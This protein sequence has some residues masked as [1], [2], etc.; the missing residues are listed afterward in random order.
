MKTTFI[1]GFLGL[2]WNHLGAADAID[3]AGIKT[4]NLVGADVNLM[5][6]EIFTRNMKHT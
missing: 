1:L 5:E 2:A 3:T 6:M 4:A